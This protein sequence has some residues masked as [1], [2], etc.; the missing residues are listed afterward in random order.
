MRRVRYGRENKHMSL[1]RVCDSYEV[2]YWKRSSVFGFGFAST[3]RAFYVYL[4]RLA[5]AVCW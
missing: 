4:G 2:R 5:L 1:L 3:D